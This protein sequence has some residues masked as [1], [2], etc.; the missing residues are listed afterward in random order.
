MN[1]VSPFSA[2]PVFLLPFLFPLLSIP[3]GPTIRK[4]ARRAAVR[5]ASG[6]PNHED[7]V[8]WPRHDETRRATMVFG[9]DSGVEDAPLEAERRAWDEIL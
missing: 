4:G 8:D 3:N 2:D 1:P 6:D 5:K 7:L 9:R